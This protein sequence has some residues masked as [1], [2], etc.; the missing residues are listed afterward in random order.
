ML[1]LKAS[2]ASWEL[3]GLLVLPGKSLRGGGAL[4]PEWGL[5]KPAPPPHFH[6][7]GLAPGAAC[8]AC[9]P[10][11]RAVTGQESCPFLSPYLE[12]ARE[13]SFVS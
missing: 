4:S 5:A 2:H 1:G 6:G 3:K 13:V 9:W 8:G 12:A 7:V 11:H 10:V